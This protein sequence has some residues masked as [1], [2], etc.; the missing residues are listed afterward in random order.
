MAMFKTTDEI[1]QIVYGLLGS[2]SVKKYMRKKPTTAND[3]EYIVI[4]CLP[5]PANVMQI[6]IFNVNYHTKNLA[7]GV[8]DI[9][10]LMSNGISILNILQKY[11]GP[12]YLID[13]ESQ[14]TISEEALGES[15]T[16]LRFSFKYINN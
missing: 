5:I 10:K 1:I 13:F 2:I 6:V 16:N 3:T 7:S 4:N 12:N 14:D 15:F 11:T 9:T 8:P